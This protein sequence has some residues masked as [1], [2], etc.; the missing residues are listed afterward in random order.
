MRTT[1][2][3]PVKTIFFLLLLGCAALYGFFPPGSTYDKNI[4][5]STP[6]IKEGGGAYRARVD[7][8]IKSDDNNNL[9]G[10]SVTLYEDDLQLGPAHSMHD[11]IRNEG[12]GAFSHWSNGVI[13]FSASDNSDPNANGKSYYIKISRSISISAYLAVLAIMYFSAQY[14]IYMISAKLELIS[15]FLSNIFSYSSVIFVTLILA[16]TLF[17]ALTE[18]VISNSGSTTRRLYE[19][20]F[21]GKN[22]IGAKEYFGA[23]FNF[24]EHHYIN[25]TLDPKTPYGGSYQFNERYKIRRTEKI[26]PKR[27]IKWRALALGGSTTFDIMLGME[28]DTWVY[29]LEE[30]IRKRSGNDYDVI[31]GGVGGYTIVEN[32]IHYIALLRHLDPDVVLLYVGINDAHARLFGDMEYDYSNYRKPWRSDGW[33]LPEANKYLSG[34]FPYRYYFL[35]SSISN[36]NATGIGAVTS[37]P[38]PGVSDWDS[39][40]KRNDTMVYRGYLE[41]LVLL[42]TAEG[43]QVI[44]IPQHFVAKNEADKIF[45]KG[46]VEHNVVNQEVANNLNVRYLD[47][48]GVN[49]PFKLDDTVDNCHF[50]EAGSEKMAELVFDYLNKHFFGHD[51]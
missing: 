29:K 28:K 34:L 30:K 3:M 33:I 17:W 46:V 10:S 40:L 39:A 42:L 6:F 11:T 44:V 13:Y 31:N 38:Y 5:L 45:I 25:Y 36:I 2:I 1:F 21:E 19:S 16:Q 20:V 18:E 41:T 7:P 24:M 4:P 12:K 22:S 26:R 51:R 14:F 43:R 50:N 48:T 27:D 23:T 8:S 32:I 49:S 37:K 47:Y 35:K 15:K 9:V